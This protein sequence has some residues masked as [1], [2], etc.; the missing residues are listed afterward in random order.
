MNAGPPPSGLDQAL[1]HETDKQALVDWV[2]TRVAP[3]YDLGNDIMSLGWH[4]R[5]KQRL[6]EMAAPLPGERVLDLACGTG[7][8]TFLLAERVAPAVVIGSDIN[9]DMMR[10]AEARAPE[11]RGRNVRWV[12][13]DATCL[14][15][16]DASFDLVT[17]S[18]AGRGL[19]DW[20]ATLREVHRVLKPGGRF[21]N[22]DFARP[23]VR[24]WDV[25]YRFWLTISGAVLGMVLHTSPTAYVY[26][27]RSMKAYPGQRWLDERMKEAGFD[28]ELHETLMWLMAYNLGTK[29]SSTAAATAT[30]P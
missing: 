6:I 26:I 29:P 19:P 11:Q 16:P 14:P 12:G 9:A 21:L 8:I 20:P 10:L 18:Y 5:W 28:T 2:F 25:L 23:P 22:L 27:P 3:N 30:D 13:A 15:F 17:C 1:R 4:K 7:D 24:A